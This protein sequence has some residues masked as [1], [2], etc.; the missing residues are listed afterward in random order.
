MS[1][2]SR[3]EAD[4]L[5]VISE[6]D[7]A[8]AYQELLPR[9]YHY[10]SLRMG[11]SQEA[12]D[13]TAATFERAWQHRA[14][15]RRDLGAFSRWVFGI[16]RHVAIAH[17]RKPENRPAPIGA[18]MPGTS[19]PTEEAAERSITFERLAAMLIEL[20]PRDREVFALKY[21]ARWKNKPISH[22]MG[23]TETNVGTILNRVLAR[24]RDGVK[25][26]K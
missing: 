17:Y 25:E 19:R 20:T 15:Y 12:Q 2:S 5:A 8:S 7:W 9:V 24:L 18:P 11:D 22:V 16:A 4:R 14:R 3:A 13:L 1:T 26:D 6:V 23:I 21:G 10:F